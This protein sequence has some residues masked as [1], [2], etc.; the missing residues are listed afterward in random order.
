MKEMFYYSQMLSVPYEQN[1]FGLYKFYYKRR[2]YAFPPKYLGTME[3][4]H[5][6]CAT[7]EKV[8]IIDR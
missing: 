6:H 4:F 7:H 2:C 1:Y 8:V 3:H 5:V